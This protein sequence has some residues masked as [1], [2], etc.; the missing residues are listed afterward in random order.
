M[1]IEITLKRSLIGRKK[2]QVQTAQALGLRK[3]N[4]TVVKERNDAI[5]GMV[6][7]IAHLISV[8][9]IA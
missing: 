4:Q 1:T 6:N 5:D 8:K 2:N 7:T 3:I 9:E